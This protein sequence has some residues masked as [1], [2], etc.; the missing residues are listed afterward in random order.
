[1]C[2]VCYDRD[3]TF[4]LKCFL[5]DLRHSLTQN[6]RNFVHFFPMA[7]VV[8]LG[9]GISPPVA[10]L[11][12]STSFSGRGLKLPKTGTSEKKGCTSIVAAVR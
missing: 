7:L 4:R 11:F 3:I 10:V 2:D 1:M 6:R 5:N 8:Y 9:H 12:V